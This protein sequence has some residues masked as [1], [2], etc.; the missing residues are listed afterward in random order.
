M[1][2]FFKLLENQEQKPTAN[3]LIGKILKALLLSQIRDKVRVTVLKVLASM[4]MQGKEL[5]N[6]S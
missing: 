6:K 5:K 4:I 3:T 2:F 1:I